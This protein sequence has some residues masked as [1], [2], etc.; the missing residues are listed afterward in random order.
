MIKHEGRDIKLGGAVEV[1]FKIR[2]L[3]CSYSNLTLKLKSIN[4]FYNQ[5]KSGL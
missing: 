5:M 1:N 2:L 4:N 3:L